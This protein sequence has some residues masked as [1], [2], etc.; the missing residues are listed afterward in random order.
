MPPSPI[1]RRSWLKATGIGALGLAASGAC[2]RSTALSRFAP[3]PSSRRGLARVIVSPDRV[4]RIVTGLR[5]FRPSG[6]VVRGERSDSKVIIH[7]YGHGGGGV[8]LSWGTAQLAVEEALRTEQRTAAV[9][10]CGAV[11]L[12]TARLLQQQG[13]TVTIYARDLP[14]NTTSNIAGAQ[15]SPY[16]VF[17]DDHLTAEFRA[18]YIRASRIA[19]RLF[20]NLVGDYYGV[21]WL[22]NY[23]IHREPLRPSRVSQELSDLFPDT[24]ELEPG[25]HPFRAPLV[26][27]FTTML[28]EPPVYLNAVLRDFLL[29]GGRLVVREF[30]A[31]QDLM[32]LAEPVIVNCTGLGAKALFDDRELIPIKGQLCVLLPQPEVDYILLTDEFLYMMPRRDGIILGGTHDRG[33]WDLAPDPAATQRILTGNAKLF[34]P[35]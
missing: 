32:S 3:T 4:I 15:W 5:P 2:A 30:H 35:D 20:Q 7:N 21:R 31:A 25:E 34:S 22:E 9:L 18:Q 24:R 17:D 16:S 12:A 28:V 29:A 14:P 6:F 33:V 13:W 1:D 19:H 8:T 10:G 27:R 23:V 11:G 26:Q